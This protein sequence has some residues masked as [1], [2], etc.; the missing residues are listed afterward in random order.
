MLKVNDI[1]E[2]QHSF[3]YERI[4]ATR[5]NDFFNATHIGDP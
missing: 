4:Y 1:R 2:H 5:Q 3:S